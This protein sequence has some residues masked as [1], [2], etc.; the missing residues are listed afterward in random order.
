MDIDLFMDQNQ[1]QTLDPKLREAYERVMG[2]A[3]AP[4]PSQPIQP[5]Q[6]D[7]PISTPQPIPQHNEINVQPEAFVQAAANQPPTSINP[8]S[9]QSANP[10]FP[11]GSESAGGPPPGMMV[12]PIMPQTSEIRPPESYSPLQQ[13]VAA[14]PQEQ[15]LRPATPAAPARQ[16]T[17]SSLDTTDATQ[18]HAYVSDEV[19]GVQQSLKLIQLVYI[20][21]G[22][23]FFAVYAL[24]WVNFFNIALPF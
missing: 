16:A 20:I 6:A 8:T 19:A 10:S 12:N 21:G 7:H 5:I 1:L 4:R 14:P 24:F 11:M 3:A 18:M 15:P 17:L 23:I 9:V 22:V 13:S 2:T